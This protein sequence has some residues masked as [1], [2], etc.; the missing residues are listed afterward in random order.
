MAL[1][2]RLLLAVFLAA[3]CRKSVAPEEQVRR[4]ITQVE[5]AITEKDLS[6]VGKFISPDYKDAE[7]YD[8]NSVMGVLRLQF[9]RY[10]TIHLLVRIAEVTVPA[11]RQAR[12]LVYAAM[13]S[14]PIRGPESLPQ[15]SADLYR[16]EVDLRENN[17]DWKVVSASWRPVNVTEFGP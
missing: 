1:P 15:L 10:P 3:A 11:P 2:R 8:R 7:Q 16:F 5:K 9:L 14:A 12:A 4:A 6:T 13:A 17:G